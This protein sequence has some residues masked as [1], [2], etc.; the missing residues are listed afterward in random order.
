MRLYA[1]VTDMRQ[2]DIGFLSVSGAVTPMN[3]PAI[4]GFGFDVSL[5]NEPSLNTIS[6]A[7][8]EQVRAVAASYGVN[9]SASDVQ[10]SGL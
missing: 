4:P 2:A 3:A 9:A 6:N 10:V 5:P 7:I 8:V 1:R